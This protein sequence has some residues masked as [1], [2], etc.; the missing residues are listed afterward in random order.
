[1][2]N[3][4]WTALSC[5]YTNG[6]S[7]LSLKTLFFAIISF[8]PMVSERLQWLIIIDAHIASPAVAYAHHHRE[9]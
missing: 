5:Y 7:P 3:Y 1:M 8:D 6:W 9:V 2:F 4:I